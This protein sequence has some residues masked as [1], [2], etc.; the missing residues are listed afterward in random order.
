MSAYRQLVLRTSMTDNYLP[1]NQKNEYTVKS[2]SEEINLQC[3]QDKI[4]RFLLT[5]IQKQTPEKTL[6]EFQN[7]FIESLRIERDNNSHRIY[8]IFTNQ[9]EAEFHHT[10]KRCC[11]ILANNWEISNQHKYIQNLLTIFDNYRIESK[12]FISPFI[13]FYSRWLDNFIN[14]R[15]FDEL[16]LFAS[17]SQKKDNWVSRYSSYL[18]FAQ[19][20]DN[21][22][23]QEQREIAKRVAQKMRQ[24]F[25]FDLAMYVA[26][27]HS[28]DS[29]IINKYKNPSILGNEILRLIKIIISKKGSLS[30]EKLAN[31][32]I[33][34]TQK[35]TLGEY[36]KNLQKYLLFFS[37]DIPVVVK[38]VEQHLQKKLS[39]WKVE[40]DEE[41]IDK[42]LILRICNRI[43]DT[44]TTENGKEPTLLFQLLLSQGHSLI[45]AILL[46]KIV[47]ISPNS[48]IHLEI[49]ISKIISYYEK[50]SA[51]QCAWLI[52]F[53]EIF[54]I[55][56]TI[57]GENIEYS[58][59][60]M[61][62]NTQ[63]FHFQSN[64][65]DYR[66]FSQLKLDIEEI[67]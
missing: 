18:L 49:C 22:N 47:L 27:S 67:I 55:M 32:F 43:I 65:D 35:Q 3:E 58:L 61:K 25:K 15:D 20:Y 7:L 60:N 66:V 37:P 51:N 34:Q 42:G 33:Q 39:D 23:S 57:Y 26:H 41:I 2:K 50:Y 21:N 1:S 36:K 10:I 63:T 62:S 4:Y 31:I 29:Y 9:Q 16:K 40:H 8:T 54:N 53:L 24:K 46:I 52:N 12:A 19:S 45:L 64:L 28:S 30:Y 48:K 59:I 44:L 17:R 13:H 5:T 38:S 11:Y 6:L 56:F 14:S